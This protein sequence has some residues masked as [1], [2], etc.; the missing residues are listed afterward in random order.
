MREQNR[1]VEQTSELRNKPRTW[2]WHSTEEVDFWFWFCIRWAGKSPPRPHNK[3]EA[4]QT[5]S[6]QLF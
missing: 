2:Y 5:E 6:Q 3:E 4:E 1:P